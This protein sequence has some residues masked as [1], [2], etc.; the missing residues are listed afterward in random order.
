MIG[1][2]ELFNFTIA[3]FPKYLPTFGRVK[4]YLL[5]SNNNK[6]DSSVKTESDT[7]TNIKDLNKTK[8]GLI[9]KLKFSTMGIQIK[10]SGLRIS[11]I[12]LKFSALVL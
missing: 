5:P 10:R 11:T 9:K 7:K 3:Y 6:E 12:I 4:V 8:H 1:M 2:R